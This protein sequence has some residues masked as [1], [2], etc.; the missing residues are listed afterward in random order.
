LGV[1]VWFLTREDTAPPG[2]PVVRERPSSHTV[3]W[4]ATASTD[5]LLRIEA[6]GKVFWEGP[7]AAGVEHRAAFDLPALGSDW[8][9]KAEG[10]S[11]ILALR[12]RVRHDGE[13][14]ADESF[15][16]RDGLS[17]VFSIGGIE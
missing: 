2:P 8:V 7:L 11:G 17:G 13:I 6:H 4:T 3:R 10:A 15:W 12:L 16:G 1:P 5:C 14:L 9:L